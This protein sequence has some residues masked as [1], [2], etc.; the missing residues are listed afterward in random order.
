MFES[1]T[2]V[3]LRNIHT[4][5][6]MLFKT[7]M[8]IVMQTRFILSPGSK[9]RTQKGLKCLPT[10]ISKEIEINSTNFWHPPCFLTRKILSS[11][12]FLRELI[13]AI[14]LS[15]K[16]LL[17]RQSKEYINV[18]IPCSDRILTFNITKIVVGVVENQG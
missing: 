14:V 12:F 9:Q 15:Q 6:Q 10:P 4:K 13:D 16:H 1:C 7:F 2:V 18:I 3:K 5:Y 17:P 11:I 8:W